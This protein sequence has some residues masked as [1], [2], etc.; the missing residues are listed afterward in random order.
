VTP[1]RWTLLIADDHPLVLRGLAQ[2][3]ATRPQFDVVS[4]GLWHGNRLFE[5]MLT[6]ANM[7]PT[8]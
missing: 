4:T 8:Q 3:I 1:L 7:I 6:S 5:R 2:L